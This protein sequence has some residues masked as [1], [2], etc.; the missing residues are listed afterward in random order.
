MRVPKMQKLGFP[1]M[2]SLDQFKSLSKSVSGGPP[3]DL[4]LLFTSAGVDL[5]GMFG[6]M[7]QRET[8]EKL[9]Q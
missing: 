5:V 3:K 2:R 4:R 8:M 6:I 1:S 9:Q 7:L